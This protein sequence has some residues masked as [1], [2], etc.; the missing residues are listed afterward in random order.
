MELQALRSTM[1]EEMELEYL[2]M[3]KKKKQQRRRPSRGQGQ[4]SNQSRPSVKED[5]WL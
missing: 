5:T 2:E 4:R 1:M 3:G